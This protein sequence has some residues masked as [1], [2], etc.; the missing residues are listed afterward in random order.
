MKIQSIV[1]PFFLIVSSVSGVDRSIFFG[2]HS[3]HYIARPQKD[4]IVDWSAGY[5]SARAT[6]D[7]KKIVYDERSPDFGKPWTAMSLTDARSTARRSASERASEMLMKT[8]ED[9]PLDLGKTLGQRAGRDE[10]LNQRIG[11]IQSLFI[12]KSE[13]TGEGYVSVEMAIPFYGRDGLMS[14]VADSGAQSIEIPEIPSDTFRDNITGIII[15]L[16]EFPEFRPTLLPKIFSD[17]GRFLYGAESVLVRT[18]IKRG[19]V[20]YHTT[21]EAAKKDPRAGVN[22]YYLYASSARDG[23][24]YLDSSEVTRLLSSPQARRAL[25]SAQVIFVLPYR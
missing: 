16:T 1:I 19:L 20:A 10:G 11:A 25:R 7:L 23:G 24:I 18:V 15:D 9:L 12:V 13:N 3:G 14:L 22:P 5:L 17:Q 21:P 6:V 4:V 2:D 8:L